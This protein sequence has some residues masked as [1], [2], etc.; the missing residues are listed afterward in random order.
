MNC[1]ELTAT[2]IPQTPALL[3]GE[4]GKGVR[5]EGEKLRL[6]R[7]EGKVVF[8][9]VFVSHHLTLFLIGNKLN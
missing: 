1:Y 4:G 9:F 6:G 5:N 2:P 7:R 3:G 8:I